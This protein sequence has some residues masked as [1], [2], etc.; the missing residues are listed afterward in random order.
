MSA[1]SHVHGI[2]SRWI[3]PIDRPPIEDGLIGIAGGRIVA[4]GRAGEVEA[5]SNEDIG[6]AIL[7]PGLI[8]AHTHLELGWC[9]GLISPRPLWEWFDE[10]IR[11]NRLPE[12]GANRSRSIAHGAAE[13]LAAGVTCVADISRTG[14]SAEI[15]RGTPIRSRCY[16]ELI[17]EAATLPNSAATLETRL[18]GLLPADG[19]RFQ[20]GISP[21]APYSVSE[22]DLSGCAEVAARLDLP[23]MMHLL[24]TTEERDW[25]GQGGGAVDDYLTRHNLKRSKTNAPQDA[26]ELLAQ[27]GI[28]ARAPLLAHV[29]YVSDDQIRRIREAGASVVW[30][31]RTH[32]YFGHET[33]RWCDMI[34]AGINVCFGTDSLASAPSLSIIEE[35]RHVAR[36]SPGTSAST[37]LECATIRAAVALQLDSVI[38]SLS[39]G[40]D[41]DMSSFQWTADGDAEPAK[42]LIHSGKSVEKIWIRGESIHQTLPQD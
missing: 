1:K 31:P 9:R 15:L 6:D 11:L 30:C 28:L 7:I 10:L 12:A 33:H 42:N 2:R 4:V 39:I 26:I 13:S 5:D 3:C 36:S 29:N 35:L 21:H 22:A 20:L 27:T 32:D 17:S 34:A 41:A 23:L 25:Y 24:E 40:K 8:N 14:A 18:S 38:G 19:T 16:V 37:L